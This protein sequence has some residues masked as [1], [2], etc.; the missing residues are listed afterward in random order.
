[1]AILR[2]CHEDDLPALMKLY[3]QFAAE[4]IVYGLVAEGPDELRQR[5]GDY[6]LVAEVDDALVGFVLGSEHTSLGLAVIPQGQR[7]LEIDDLYVVPAMRQRGIGGELLQAVEHRARTNGIE[8]FL[9]YSAVK[10]LDAI[11]KFYRCHGF[12]SWF[13]QMY[14]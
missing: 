6:C 11:V 3:E 9:L 12:N 8:H 13:I 14:K 7:Y 1:M 4:E 5:L 10:D 2:Q